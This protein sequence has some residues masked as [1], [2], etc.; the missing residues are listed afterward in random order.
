MQP[1]NKQQY[2]ISLEPIL[3]DILPTDSKQQQSRHREVNSQQP[4]RSDV[5]LLWGC[6]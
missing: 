2:F 1:V 6:A 4:K 3:E 5:R